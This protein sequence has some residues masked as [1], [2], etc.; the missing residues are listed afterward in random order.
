MKKNIKQKICP[1]NTRKRRI[2]DENKIKKKWEGRYTDNNKK[3][4]TNT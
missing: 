2:C 3:K 4:N 1:L